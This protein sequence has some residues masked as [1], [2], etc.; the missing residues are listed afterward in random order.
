MVMGLISDNNEAAFLDEV[1]KLASWC[2]LNCFSLNVSTM[3]EMV[4]DFT[5][6]Q[7]W[8]YTQH[9]PQDTSNESEQFEIPQ[10]CTSLRI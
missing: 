9:P 10:E 1:E 2:Q 8:H 4:V 7:Q 3:K 6:R 5:L